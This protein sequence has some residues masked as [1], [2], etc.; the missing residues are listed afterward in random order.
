MVAPGVEQRLE[1]RK[2]LPLQR[3]QDAADAL[4]VMSQSWAA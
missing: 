4:F 3:E 2:L 1:R